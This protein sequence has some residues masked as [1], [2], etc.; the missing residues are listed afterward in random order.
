VV[1]RSID[2]CWGR[3][4]SRSTAPHVMANGAAAVDQAQYVS[5]LLL[6]HALHA[7]FRVLDNAPQGPPASAV[8]NWGSNLLEFVQIIFA[9]SFLS[10]PSSSPFLPERHLVPSL[11]SAASPPSTALQPRSRPA[12]SHPRTTR[13]PGAAGRARVIQSGPD[14][15]DRPESQAVFAPHLRVPGY[16]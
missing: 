16:N 7:F 15:R 6:Q 3:N 1:D 13:S 8:R 5:A 10:S 14:S 9:I 2:R 4:D 12:K 11:D